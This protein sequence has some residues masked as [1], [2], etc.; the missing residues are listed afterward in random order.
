MAYVPEIGN[1]DAV[2]QKWVYES[3]RTIALRTLLMAQFSGDDP[4]NFNGVVSLAERRLGIEFDELQKKAIFAAVKERVLLLTGGPGTGKTTTL[5]GIIRV[6]ESEDISFALCA[7]TGRAA[8]RISELTGR[9]AKTLH[10]LLEYAPRDGEYVFNR[11]KDNQLQYDAVI[12]DESSIDER[13]SLVFASARSASAEIETYPCRRR[14]YK[15]PPVGA[16]NVFRDLPRMRLSADGAPGRNTSVQAQ[17]SLIVTNAHAN[18]E[19][20]RRPC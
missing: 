18:I 10:R 15:P 17:Q 20:A 2:Y 5:N 7:P 19:R 6:F 9:E 13:F 8:K 11:N 12:A 16:G 14:G 4:Q 1:S 3:E